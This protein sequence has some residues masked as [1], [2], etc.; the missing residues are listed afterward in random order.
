MIWQSLGRWRTLRIACSTAPHWCCHRNLV[1]QRMAALLVPQLWCCFRRVSTDGPMYT[2]RIP[3][4][5]HSTIYMLTP[6]S[7]SP[8]TH[9]LLYFLIGNSALLNTWYICLKRAPGSVC[10]FVPRVN[11]YNDHNHLMQEHA[12]KA[13]EKHFQSQR[14]RPD[15]P[16]AM[17]QQVRET[18]TEDAIYQ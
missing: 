15:W 6:T 5:S 11:G 4:A 14:G 17:D 13:V 7:I 3:T 9:A 1:K 8:T 12:E 2:W 18:R 16:E 10:T